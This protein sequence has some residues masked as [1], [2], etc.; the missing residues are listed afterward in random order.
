MSKINEIK[1]EL[2]ET[3]DIH[4]QHING[5]LTVVW[6]DWD[7]LIE[8][9]PKMIYLTNVNPDEIKGPH[10]H[11]KRHSYF[12]CVDGEVVFILKNEDGEYVEIKSNSKIPN[13][14]HVPPNTPCAHLNLSKNI[15]KI[16]VLAN[17]S[18][19]PNDNEMKNI[20]FIDYNWSKWK[21]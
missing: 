20:Q 19:K 17:I 1:L 15:S 5:S 11:L 6:R 9:A 8:H 14:I 21:K 12:T 13:L 10:L 16:L 3:K 2:H 4:D 7:K 18:W